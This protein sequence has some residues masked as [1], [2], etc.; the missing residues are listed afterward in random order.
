MALL[1]SGHGSRGDLVT[2]PAGSAVPIVVVTVPANERWH[3]SVMEFS[4]ITGDNTVSGLV[5]GDT[6]QTGSI[7]VASFA[8]ATLFA[9]TLSH[10]IALEPSDT[11]LLDPDG[12]GVAS[13]IWTLNCW[14]RREDV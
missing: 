12:A 3:I 8:A 14:R 6:S 9:V 4:R 2:I 1:L 10:P 5:F 7:T 11:I 13:G